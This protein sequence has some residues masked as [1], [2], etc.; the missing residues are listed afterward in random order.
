MYNVFRPQIIII[1]TFFGFSCSL[2]SE[3]EF[4][5]ERVNFLYQDRNRF[6]EVHYP[7]GVEENEIVP[8]VIAFH[9]AGDS[10]PNFRDGT[11]LNRLADQFGFI[12][13]YPSATGFNWAEGCN[14]IRPDLDGVDDVGFAEALVDHLAATGRVDTERVFAI[15]YSQGGVFTHHLACMKSDIF[16]GVAMYAGPMGRVVS[17]NCD[18]K[19]PVN[20]LLAHGT[21][22]K[23]LPFTG[24]EDG[25]GTLLSAVESTRKWAQFNGC[26]TNLKTQPV[27][28]LSEKLIIHSAQFCDDDVRVQ[29]I[30]WS[31]GSHSW[32][33]R[34]IRIEERM[35]AFF[36]LSD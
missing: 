26:F 14:C 4:N 36:G 1:A 8:L 24:V 15:G 18:P 10:G 17:K 33:R 6:A 12:I 32:P 30:E 31:G 29:L 16:A 11:G 21:D 5:D 2:F 9:G 27:D 19:E 35:I 28:F 7:G 20:V 25:L 34:E 22:D 3:S 23:V 13:A